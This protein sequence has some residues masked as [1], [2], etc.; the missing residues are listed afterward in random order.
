MKKITLI[1]IG[2]LL[3]SLAAC[4]QTPA[5]TPTTTAAP[6]VGIY[7]PDTVAI[8]GPD[9]TTLLAATYRY[10]EGWETKSQFSVT[11]EASSDIPPE[12]AAALA[13]M[14]P[15]TTYTPGC[16]TTELPTVNKTQTFYDAAGQVT[17]Q[18]ITY[19]NNNGT[20]KLETFYTYD[21]QGRRLTEE[22]KQ[23]ATGAEKP[24]TTVMT[25][26]YGEIEEGTLGEAKR[27]NLT[28]Q[29]EYDKQ[30]RL[31][32]Y[33]TLMDGQLFMRYSYTYDAAGNRTGSI[34]YVQGAMVT[35]TK[36]TY[37]LV[38]VSEAFAEAFP[39]FNREK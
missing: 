26:V 37:R 24:H 17:S 15:A 39:M 34:Q 31:I 10:E 4:S 30:N 33:N 6:T 8:A 23:Y 16:V 25:Y 29:L 18:V 2:A 13:T 7:V 11:C 5:S 21:Q 22:S 32:G 20:D 3:L 27:S 19:L 38:Q 14:L 36:T 28:Y 35:D 12:L 9:G 1:L